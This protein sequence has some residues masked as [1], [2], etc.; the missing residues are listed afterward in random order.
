M[1]FRCLWEGVPEMVFDGAGDVGFLFRRIPARGPNSGI[2]PFDTDDLLKS[3]KQF[4]GKKAR[5]A[6]GIDQQIAAG[7]HFLGD[8]GEQFR[9]SIVHLGKP[10][11]IR[12]FAQRDA[13]VI[14]WTRIAQGGE[15][16]IHAFA[17]DW[18]G[19]DIHKVVGFA[20]VKSNLP[21]VHM[22]R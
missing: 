21:S 14:A 5:A 9:S 16:G 1:G 17:P 10:L 3:G 6:I 4:F 19:N 18:A 11:L 2:T 15:F 20:V 8:P 13:G 7:S 12:F 22:N